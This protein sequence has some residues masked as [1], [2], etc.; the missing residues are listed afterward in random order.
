MGSDHH[1]AEE[2][3]THRVTVDG[4]WVETHP[5]TNAEFASFVKASGHV[6]IAE[7]PLEPTDFPG[8]PPE[9]L[10]PGS[11]VFTGTTA[12][13]DL[14]HINLWWSW[15]P[16]ASWRHPEGP[17]SSIKRRM[18][19]PVVQ[20]AYADAEA[21]AAWAGRALPTEAEWEAAARGGL[22]H[23][24]FTW[25]DKPD[26]ADRASELLA[27]RVPLAPTAR[28]R[29]DHPGRLLPAQPLRPLRHGRQRLGLDRRLVCPPP[30]GGDW[31]RVLRPPQPTRRRQG[32]KLRP[33]P[34][35][36]PTAPQGDQGRIIPLRGQ[37]LP[38]IPTRSPP[39]PDDRHRN[40]PHRLP[41]RPPT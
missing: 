24:R 21:Y 41:L 34:T 36:V 1:Y 35:P 37:L 16:G 31:Q 17:G 5:V 39:A 20:V 4:F 14:R 6:T 19:H 8:A 38:A 28:V 13:V 15:T 25:G 11:M 33:P 18:D 2:R 27:R 12:P 22:D 26:P 9:N 29:H 10:Q 32:R 30:P 3:P 23:T 7:R 40:E